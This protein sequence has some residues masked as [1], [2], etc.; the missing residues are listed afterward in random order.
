ML[1]YVL[2]IRPHIWFTDTVNIVILLTVYEWLHKLTDAH[3]L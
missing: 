3:S 1:I 2:F